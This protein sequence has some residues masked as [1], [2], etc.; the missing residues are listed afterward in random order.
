MKIHIEKKIYLEDDGIHGYV[1]KE[2]L[3][4]QDKKGK[5]LFKPLAYV[6]S[7]EKAVERIYRIKVRSSTAENL[8]EFIKDHRKIIK[9]IR[10]LLGTE[11]GK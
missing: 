1:I 7:V 8:K 10:E 9:E 5:E 3:N 11:G 2:Y 6:P 4:K